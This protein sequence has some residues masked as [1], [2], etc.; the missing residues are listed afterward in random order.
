MK[1]ATFNATKTV[2]MQIKLGCYT[3]TS[4][5][6][7]KLILLFNCCHGFNVI[8]TWHR[9]HGHKCCRISLEYLWLIKS[10]FWLKKVPPENC[11]VSEIE[12]WDYLKLSNYCSFSG[13]KNME[14]HV[15][16]P[17]CCKNV[18]QRPKIST[19]WG[20]NAGFTKGTTQNMYGFM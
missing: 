14:M 13:C 18:R 6:V 11:P 2:S 9:I 20:S 16:D 8:I 1:Y 10:F 12:I 5:N 19:V 4:V 17:K 7:N 3:A 15:K